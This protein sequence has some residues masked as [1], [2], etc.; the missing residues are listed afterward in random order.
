[1]EGAAALALCLPALALT[2]IAVGLLDALNSAAAIPLALLLPAG[3]L[4]WVAG[5][6]PRWLARLPAPRALRPDAEVE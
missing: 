5:P 2:L 4:Y 3:W 1:V 6:G